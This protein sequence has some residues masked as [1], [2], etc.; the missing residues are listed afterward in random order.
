MQSD[1][2]RVLTATE[3]DRVAGGLGS[4]PWGQFGP[5]PG[6]VAGPFPLPPSNPWPQVPH[7]PWPPWPTQTTQIP[8]I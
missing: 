1:S 4:G 8:T 7:D 3:L 2:M 5:G 6:P